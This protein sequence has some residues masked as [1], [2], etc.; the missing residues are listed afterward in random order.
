MCEGFN[1]LVCRRVSCSNVS[2]ANHY[3]Q[4][5]HCASC[6]PDRVQVPFHD[7]NTEATR[8]AEMVADNVFPVNLRDRTGFPVVADDVVD[9][10]TENDNDADAVTINSRSYG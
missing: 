1:G 5:A 6:R 9:D 4:D 2:I 10:I 8:I 3:G 7:L